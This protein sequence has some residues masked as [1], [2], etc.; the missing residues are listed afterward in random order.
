MTTYKGI[1]HVVDLSTNIMKPCE[2]CS[3]SVGSDKLAESINHYIEKHGYKLLHAGTETIHDMN[4]N[5]WHTTVAL[6]GK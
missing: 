5:P 1:K 3:T 2:H 4:G 6:L